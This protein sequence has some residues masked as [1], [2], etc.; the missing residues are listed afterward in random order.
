MQFGV[1]KTQL[2]EVK[3]KLMAIAME[4][5]DP[6]MLLEDLTI[7]LMVNLIRFKETI[8]QLRVNKIQ[9]GAA[10]IMSMEKKMQF[11]VETTQ[12]MDI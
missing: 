3:T 11:K 12:L 10:R 9:F 5:K 2:M 7:T 4:S 6:K 8:I 1:I